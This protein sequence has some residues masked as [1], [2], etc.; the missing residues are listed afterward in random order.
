MTLTSIAIIA[1]IIYCGAAFLQAVSLAGKLQPNKPGL[2]VGGLIAVF[3][4]AWLLHVWIDVAHGQNLN[5]FN[6]MSVVLW[7][8]ALLL[9]IA[10]V[11]KPVENL[12]LIVFPLAALSIL[13]VI[14]F[15]SSYVINTGADPKKLIHILLAIFTMAVMC[16]AALQAIA[17]W[18]QERALRVKP[19]SKLLVVLPAMQTMESLLFQT[20]WLGFILLTV[21]IVSAF[22]S[23]GNIFSDVMLQKS[24]FGVFS[25]VVFAV[26]LIGRH[27]SGWRGKVAIRFTLIGF[28]LLVVAYFSSQ[29]ALEMLA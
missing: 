28:L 12:C 21:V 6:M 20:I 19:S 26:L 8:V 22:I 15:P 1:I 11:R 29:I 16:I 4:H 3:I 2:L 18:L 10:A 25:W 14:L 13:L 5:V 27:V 24:L 23:F 17:V 7:L 9:I